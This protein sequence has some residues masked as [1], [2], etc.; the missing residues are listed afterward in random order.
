MAMQI[1]CRCGANLEVPPGTRAVVCAACQA[2]VAVPQPERELALSE[3]VPAFVPTAS[4]RPRRVWPFAVGALVLVGGGIA[5]AVHFTR[6][7]SKP[8]ARPAPPVAAITVVDATPVED[9]VA[10]SSPEELVVLARAAIADGDETRLAGLL[11]PAAFGHGIDA[12]DVAYGG[13][14]VAAMIA[15][16]FGRHGSPAGRAVT[17]TWSKIARDGDVAWIADELAVGRPRNVMTSQLAFRDGNTWRIAAWHFGELV[18]NPVAARLAAAGKLPPPAALQNQFD[19]DHQVHDAFVAAFASK[20]AFAAAFSDR[21]DALNLGSAP[22]ERVLGG[23]AI[24]RW[25]S[26]TNHAFRLQPEVTAGRVSD[27]VGWAAGN[28]EYTLRSTQ[29]YRVLV[30]LV[31]ERAG[32]RIVL[33]QFTNAGPIAE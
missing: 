19:D 5:L 8:R 2:M 12:S 20:E 21:A 18:R 13:P 16:M 25:A 29:I 11:A 24:K 30:V 7:D 17:S 3:T 23:P 4:P 33:A 10:A 22:F 27:R 31:R 6:D 14:A 15:R 9:V 28:V 32:W 1:R 26:R